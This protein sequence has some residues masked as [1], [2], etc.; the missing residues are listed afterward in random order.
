MLAA[1][2][3]LALFL[4]ILSTAF[5]GA[6]VERSAVVL[7][8][9]GAIGPATSDYVHR[10]LE[11]ARD[12][13]AAVV[14]LRMDTP[15]GLDTS[16]RDII[17]DILASPVPVVTYVAPSGA[18]AAS[19]GTYILYASHVAAMAPGTNLGAA[20]PVQ[21]GGAPTPIPEPEKPA[22][23]DE[24]EKGE[25]E[26]EGAGEVEDEGAGETGDRGA[27]E[28]KKEPK[29]ARR[30]HPTIADKA[31]SDAVA[32]IR[33]LAQM[34]GRNAD[35]A[36]KAVRE[37]ASL[38]AEEALEERVI[39]L[40]AS[41]VGNLL[42][43]LDGRTVTVQGEE[44]SLETAG[45][46]VV[47]IEPDWR[48]E[49]LAVITNPNVAYILL[50]LGIYGLIL[51]F[52]NPGAL[53]PGV[54][55]GIFLL[56]GLY[57]L[58][59]LPVNYA[60]LALILLGVAFMVAEA[61]VPAFG[62]LGIGGVI[63][64]VIGSV[65]LLETDV[66]GYGIDWPVIIAVAATS[67]AFF[68]IVLAMAVKARARPVVSGPEEL[69]G[70]YGRVAEW[71]GRVGRVRVHSESWNASASQPLKPGKRVRVTAREGLTL[72]VEPADERGEE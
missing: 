67:G 53:V 10:S 39:D 20:T 25:K 49:L 28:E 45:L 33:S 11:K 40:I 66:P 18:R 24:D 54:L 57:A 63:A 23:E 34:R 70:S 30:P 44:R 42:E 4:V 43:M 56:L 46:A 50:M 48:T 37:A 41:D 64:F 13:N 62:I 60:G 21:I 27:G 12:A 9:A 17:Q 47:E 2:L 8:V 31:V 16:M 36:E 32:Y 72:V 26:D 35:W 65:I 69:I 19:A 22:R 6:E 1:R 15:G 29:Q 52:S 61:F 71:R 68:M 58:Q 51:E 5:T 38:S 59:L 14:I 7:N 3:V 55:G